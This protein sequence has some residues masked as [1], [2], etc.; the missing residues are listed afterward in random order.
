MLDELN[1]CSVAFRVQG[2]GYRAK[3]S[4]HSVT[5]FVVCLASKRSVAFFS[6]FLRLARRVGWIWAQLFAR[7][8]A[9]VLCGGT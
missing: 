6:V 5:F 2:L 4:K 8:G 1:L 7:D 9:Y 3:V